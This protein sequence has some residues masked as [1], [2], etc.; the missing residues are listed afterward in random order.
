MYK[1]LFVCTGATCRSPMANAIFNRK[2][3]DYNLSSIKSN[4]AGIS[5]EYGSVINP[6][7]KQALHSFGIAKV[8]GKPT[9]IT[10]KHL[11][12]YNLVVCMTQDHKEALQVMVAKQFVSK[13]VCIKDFCGYDIADPYGSSQEVYN[14]SMTK[15]ALAVDKII[16]VLLGNGIAKRK[17]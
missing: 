14:D 16:E 6:K 4:F 2:V 5:V 17:K 10:G 8:M 13:I 9:Q 11:A 3:K 15:I 12:D 1:I 7:S